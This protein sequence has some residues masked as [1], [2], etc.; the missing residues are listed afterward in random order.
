LA[1]AAS[2]VLSMGAIREAAAHA[3]PVTMVP[4]ANAVLSEAPPEVVIRFSERVDAK[5]STLEVLD[6]R[7]ERVDHGDATVDRADPWR[8]RV[9]VHALTDGAYT[10]TW[11][12]LSADDGHVT[13]GAHV[14]VVGAGS[15][16]GPAPPVVPEGPGFRPI[17]RWLVVVGSAFL[18]GIPVVGFWLRHDLGGRAPGSSLAWL[19][20]AMILVGGALD[21]GLQ[22]WD[23]AGERP[24]AEVLGALLTTRSGSLWLCRSGLLLGL[25]ALWAGSRAGSG[26]RWRRVLALGLATAVV[27]SGGLVTHSATLVEG[28]TLALGVEAV[29]LVAVALW[30]GG[31]VGFALMLRP[32]IATP[33]APT[34]TSALAL[35]IPAFSQ[36]AI[37]AV[38]ALALSGLLLARQHLTA[39]DELV[40]TPYG[41]WLTAKLVVFAAMLTV[42]A[43][44]QRVGYWLRNA[45]AAG[46]SDAAILARFRRSLRTEA[47]LGLVALLF[48]AALASTSPTHLAVPDADAAFHHERMLDD[49]RVRLDVTPLLPGPNTIQLTVTDA[50]GHPLAEATG[51]L[52]QLVPTVGGIG[53]VTFSL[54]KTGPGVFAA[55]EAVLGIVGRWDGRLV[56]QREGAYD[57]NDRFELTLPDRPSFATHHAHGRTIPLDAVTIWSTAGIT[58]ATA[59][60][61]VVSR[62]ARRAIRRLVADADRVQP[63]RP[64]GGSP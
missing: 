62:R 9:G 36:L 14:F 5:A 7:G 48:A 37:P 25:A 4:A 3:V 58:L 50:A 45:V 31:L 47:G 20:G 54:T 39:W 8:F 51:A 40:R 2:V 29:H 26:N 53:P 6:G 1:L 16:P 30:V 34:A 57:V 27:I 13:S 63:G 21:L 55:A 35:A 17:A 56:V 24:M 15:A 41:R 10:V 60:L 44:H 38:G 61:W 18:L 19:G 42:A 23:L 43:Y 33:T 32:A 11:R 22:A 46:R 52:V 49:T 28:R 12:V 59:A 64:H